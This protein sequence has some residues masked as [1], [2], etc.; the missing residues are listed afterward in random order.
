MISWACVGYFT[1]NAMV[2][3]SRGVIFQTQK[4]DKV[5]QLIEYAKCLYRNQDPRLQ[6]AFPLSKPLDQ[7]PPTGWTSRTAAHRR[8][9]SRG[10]P[11]PLLSPMGL[12]ERRELLPSR[13]R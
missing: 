13:C 8:H 3:P 12:P 2:V 6:A 5:I 10:E 11:D 9:T 4:E 1:M 7:Q